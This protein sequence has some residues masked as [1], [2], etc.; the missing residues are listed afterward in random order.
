MVQ[1]PGAK[2]I[3]QDNGAIPVRREAGGVP[4]IAAGLRHLADGE[5]ARKAREGAGDRDR[6]VR[7][8]GEAAADGVDAVVA[9]GAVGGK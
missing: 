2:A 3:G 9:D 5:V 6:Q 8:G 7:A 4:A 1:A